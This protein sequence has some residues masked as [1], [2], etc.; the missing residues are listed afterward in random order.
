V[1]E[2][3]AGYMVR[4]WMK[5]LKPKAEEHARPTD[6]SELSTCL[7]EHEGKGEL[8]LNGCKKCAFYYPGHVEDCMHCGG[9]CA[10]QHCA[11]MDKE[12]LVAC[13]HS[14]LFRECHRHCVGPLTDGASTLEN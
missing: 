14:E 6:S 11:G 5:G 2:D 12:G 10:R 7:E 1:P 8:A 3:R 13:L 4:K 9:Q